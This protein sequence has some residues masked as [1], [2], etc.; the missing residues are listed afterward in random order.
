MPSSA[1]K[2]KKDA[3]TPRYLQQ[4]HRRGYSLLGKLAHRHSTHDRHLRADPCV[5]VRVATFVFFFYNDPATPE[6]YPLPLHDAL[7][8]SRRTCR[9][10]WNS[11]PSRSVR[12]RNRA[13]W[14]RSEE[15][16]SELQSR[17]HLVCRLLLEKK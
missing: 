4:L 14:Y 7:P 17:L 2:K 11:R 13:R 9:G 12:C 15:H 1:C 3:R 16:T 6:I 10:A 8:I 5:Q